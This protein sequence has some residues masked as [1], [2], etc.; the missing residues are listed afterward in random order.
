MTQIEARAPIHIHGLEEVISELLD[1]IARD[2]GAALASSH[3]LQSEDSNPAD[4]ILMRRS[5]QMSI[6]STAIASQMG[7]SVED[8]HAV[9]LATMLHD[10][11]LFSK[12]ASKYQTELS[13]V[14][15]H[16]HYIGHPHR[17]VEL[18]SQIKDVTPLMRIVMSQV[19][20]Q[21]DGG[22]FPKGLRGHQLNQLSRIA[23]LVDAYLCMLEPH[24]LRHAIVPAD[25]IAYLVYH[26][27]L[28]RFDREC[29]E[30]FLAVESIYPV[31]SRVEL[32][33]D[34][35][36]IVLRSSVSEPLNPIVRL[37][38]PA[39]DII[40]LRQNHST[41]KRPL[42]GGTNDQQRLARSL[43]SEILWTPP[44]VNQVLIG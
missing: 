39:Q 24:P 38:T 31:G 6:L 37:D 7:F 29:V 21:V 4:E 13:Y 23:N 1:G 30:A 14:D 8:C 34:R 33:D 32:D 11:S 28:G 15:P 41:V 10:L 3:S 20:E 25:S 35:P 5:M 17:S 44:Q 19:H 12:C 42:T 18:V 40:D 22:G 27:V 2:T 36:A 9:G 16:Q 43:F 26:T